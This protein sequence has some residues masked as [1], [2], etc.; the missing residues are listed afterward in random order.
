MPG[1]V[2]RDIGVRL[3]FKFVELVE[4]VWLVRLSVVLSS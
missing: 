2:G 4:L 3:Q 1:G